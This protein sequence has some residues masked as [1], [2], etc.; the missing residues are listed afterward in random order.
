MIVIGGGVAGM[1]AALVL[2]RCRRRVLVCDDGRPRNAVSRGVHGFLTRAGMPPDE[3]LRVGREQ[4]LVYPT[5]SWREGRV[6]TAE[7]QGAGFI[8]RLADG[9]RITASTV[10][11][12]TGLIDEMPAVEGFRQFWGHSA[13][14]CPF[15]DGWEVRD[16]RMVVLGGAVGVYGFTLELRQW[17]SELFLCTDGADALTSEEVDHCRRLGIQVVKTKVAALEGSGVQVERLRF[18]DGSELPT[19]VVFLATYQHQRSPLAE[20][21]GCPLSDEGAITVCPET[22]S[23]APGLW[24]AG[25]ASSGLQMAMI[26]AAEGLKAAHAINE[27]LVEQEIAGT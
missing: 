23:V 19:R 6:E 26:A 15:C 22:C 11:L 2:G 17:A 8:V 16:Q 12:A 1:S 18:V 27:Y 14:I 7:R 3:F 24:V 5:V 4:V 10:L 13:F 25:N 21:L 9:H 20:S